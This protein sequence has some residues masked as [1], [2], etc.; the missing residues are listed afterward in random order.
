[1]LQAP[2]DTVLREAAEPHTNRG[3]EVR[4]ETLPGEGGD[5]R[6]PV[7]LR[8]PEVIHGLRNL[9]Q[10]AVD[11][12]DGFVWIDG[13][14]T[15]ERISVRILDDGPGFPPHVFA[16]IGDPFVRSRREG[17]ARGDPRRPAYEGMGLG[18]FIAKTL[19]ER[20][21]AEINFFNGSDP[22]E[23]EPHTGMRGGAIVEVVW[24][25]SEISPMGDLSRRPLGQ[26]RPIEA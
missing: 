13:S 6:Q 20:S 23:H 26:N 15:D 14:W 21:G 24:P 22:A 10:N 19:L 2:L 18:L 7:V 16:R 12:A 11:F 3:K 9:I 25:R 8:R 17:A 4:I 5:A 1:L